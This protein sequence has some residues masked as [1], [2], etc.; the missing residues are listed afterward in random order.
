MP[1]QDVRRKGRLLTVRGVLPLIVLRENSYAHHLALA[2]EEHARA[3][4]TAL[5]ARG[6]AYT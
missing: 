1:R 3:G 5:H 6:K 2:Y 4:E